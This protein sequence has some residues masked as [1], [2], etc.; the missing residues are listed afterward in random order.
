MIQDIR[1]F[2]DNAGTHIKQFGIKSKNAIVEYT[3]KEPKEVALLCIPLIGIGIQFFKE[4]AEMGPIERELEKKDPKNAPDRNIIIEHIKGRNQIKKNAIL[5]LVIHALVFGAL[6]VFF[7]LIGS[8]VCT[9]YCCMIAKNLINIHA[10]DKTIKDLEQKKYVFETPQNN[11]Q[12]LF[13][14]NIVE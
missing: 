11:N 10:N 5:S 7:P 1:N 2:F 3:T 14:S 9:F 12:Q 8:A 4:R 6:T 13:T